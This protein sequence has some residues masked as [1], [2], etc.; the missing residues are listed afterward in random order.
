MD[1]QANESYA[2]WCKLKSKEKTVCGHQS[3]WRTSLDIWVL[4]INVDKTKI[5]DSL[6]ETQK[7]ATNVKTNFRC[8][9]TFQYFRDVTEKLGGCVDGN[10]TRITA[11]RNGFRQLLPIITNRDLSPK[12]RGNTFTSCIRKSL[13]YGCKT[14]PVSSETIRCLTSADNGMVNWIS[15]VQLKQ[16]IRTQE[17]LEK[18][19]IISVPEEI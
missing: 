15:G 14:W 13:L 7:P 12:N 4:S 2:R 11:A 19:I 8:V 5:L 9:P 16:R 3:S 6:G 17:L 18:L 10:S 1:C